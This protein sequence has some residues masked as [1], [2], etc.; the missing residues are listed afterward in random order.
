MSS[1]D[2]RILE[3]ALKRPQ[4][5]FKYTALDGE[6]REWTR[7]LVVNSALFFARPSMFNDPLDC[8]IPPSFEADPVDI[9]R[10]WREKWARQGRPPRSQEE[11]DRL[12][13]KSATES[14]RQELTKVYYDLLDTYG[15]ACFNSRPD[16]FLL[17]SYYA[18]SHAGVA[19]RFD[20]GDK[21]LEQIPQPYLPLKVEYAKDFPRV[22]LY[23]P[24]RLRFVQNT[25]G[26]KAEAWQHE[27]EWRL[28]AI[29]RSGITRMPTGMI[30]GL[31]L[32]LRT[33]P[34]VESEARGWI[35]EAGRDIELMRVR[36][37]ANS[38][39]LEVVP[40]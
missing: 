28:I 19:V 10:F 35:A 17:W 23:D 33:P 20:T 34:Q 18:A 16:N 4:K 3:I 21:F 1:A 13:A 6:R 25:L 26:T 12:I 37:R 5:F 30:D 29:G 8:R 11:L 32:G 36:H 40:A 38:F 31:V 15:I 27:E 9:E 22:S 39:E 2:P 14:G 7:N 24:D